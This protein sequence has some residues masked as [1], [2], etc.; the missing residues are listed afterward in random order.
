MVF[1]LAQIDESS[2]FLTVERFAD[3]VDLI[4]DESLATHCLVGR[5]KQ[6]HTFQPPELPLLTA[7]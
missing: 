6:S 3:A 1:N 2:G 5:M 4:G 7:I